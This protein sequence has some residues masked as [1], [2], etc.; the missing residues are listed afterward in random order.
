MRLGCVQQPRVPL[1]IA[2][3][4]DRSLRIAAEMGDAWI[5]YGDPLCTDLAPKEIQRSVALQ[6]QSLNAHC[7]QGGRDPASIS[8]IYLIGNTSE[9][10]LES[11]DRF[12]EFVGRY[13][14]LGFTDFVF[15]TPGEDDSTWRAP[16]GIVEEIADKYLD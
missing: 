7:A 16:V 6:A 10:P 12:D 11:I 1:A 3:T 13:R 2:A 15:H 8:R 4:G 14:E 9:Q 5:T